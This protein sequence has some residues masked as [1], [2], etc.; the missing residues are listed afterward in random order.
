MAPNPAADYVDVSTRPDQ[1]PPAPP[2]PN[3]A[4]PHAFQVRL[5]NGRGQVVQ[6]GGPRDGLVRLNT[7]NYRPGSTT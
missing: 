4:N 7:R 5:H 3:Q 1:A 2:L 6:A